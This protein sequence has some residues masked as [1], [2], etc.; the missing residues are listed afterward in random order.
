MPTKP[1][2]LRLY[3]LAVATSIFTSASVHAVDEFVYTVQVGDHPWNIAQR[4]LKDTSFAQQLT[5]LNRITNDRR[6]PPGTQ[7]RIP[8][9]WL[10]LQSTR[11]RVLAA[12]GQAMVEQSGKPVR[13]AV[14]G[15]ELPT[16]AQLR[17]GPG[18]SVL[19]E[20]DDGSRVMMRQASE[21]RLVQSD[22]RLLDGGFMVEL[23]LIRGGLENMVTPLHRAP[24]TR[25]E[26]R[27]P[28]AVAAVRGTRFRVHADDQTAWTEVLDGAVQVDNAAGGVRANAGF[29]TIAQVGRAPEPPRSLLAAPDLSGL[30]ERLERLPVNWPLAPV[31]GAVAYRSQVAPDTR[32]ETLLSDELTPQARIRITDIEDGDFVLRVRATDADGLEGLVAERTIRVHARP[33]APILI[34]P[35]PDAVVATPRPPF[36]W[37]I[38][39]PGWHYRLEIRQGPSTEGAPLVAQSVAEAQVGA[40]ATDLAPGLYHWRVASVVPASGRQ[41]PWGD[42]QSFRVVPPAP[43]AAPV[44]VQSGQVT[45]RWPAVPHAS[46]Y[47]LQVA[48]RADFSQPVVD[49]RSNEPQ[50]LLHALT[51]GTYHLRIRT[52]SQDG[53]TGPWSRPQLFVV[54][55]PPPPA[56]DPSPWRALLIV[57]PALILLGL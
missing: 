23:E 39:D 43:E 18:S 19:L 34:R 38:P 49:V 57:L 47:E 2:T 41:G 28:A 12:H 6:V 20:F 52:T 10:K 15:E 35:A 26:I 40:L 30:P 16:R 17:T 13:A 54:P 48:T 32:F 36:Q 55:E 14:A 42:T 4:Y 56:P 51:P 21:L 8:A 5:R 11:I 27:T 45:I 29:G 22:R 31:P 9:P 50:H 24:A 46:G 44:Q 25:F 1:L 53:F 37:T 33:Q 3:H 7:L